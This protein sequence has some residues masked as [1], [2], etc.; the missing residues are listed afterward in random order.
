MWK[1][2]SIPVAVVFWT[3]LVLLLNT[4]FGE[5]S[6]ESQL[7]GSRLFLQQVLTQLAIGVDIQ[8]DLI[9][10]SEENRNG[11]RLM[12]ERLLSRKPYRI[13]FASFEGRGVN[14]VPYSVI[15]DKNDSFNVFIKLPTV[16][17]RERYKDYYYIWI[18]EHSS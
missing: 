7:I 10:G 8:Q 3:L 16:F 11:I 15:F 14:Y 2:I 9:L 17:S 18:F 12:K 13:E 1:T 4:L 5:P 6:Y